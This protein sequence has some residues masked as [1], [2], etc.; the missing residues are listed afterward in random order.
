MLTFVTNAADTCSAINQCPRLRSLDLF[1][2]SWVAFDWTKATSW[3]SPLTRLLISG[4]P[5]DISSLLELG[6]CPNLA[7]L[8]VLLL[9]FR[10]KIGSPHPNAIKLHAFPESL[11]GLMRR[12]QCQITSLRLTTWRCDVRVLPRLLEHL[13]N[14]ESLLVREKPQFVSVLASALIIRADTKADIVLPRLKK[15]TVEEVGD[16]PISGDMNAISAFKLVDLINSRRIL[17]LKEVHLNLLSETTRV[18]ER[19]CPVVHHMDI[20]IVR[21]FR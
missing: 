8:K 1:L 9:E 7:T 17:P 3:Q 6:F 4:S 16:D 18:L 15:L 19:L 2:P 14:V 10:Y 11:R 5:E 20:R 12:S 21:R 13:F